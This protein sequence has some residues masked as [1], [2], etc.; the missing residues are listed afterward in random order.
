MTRR[1]CPV[2]LFLALGLLAGCAPA[3]YL[4]HP[5]FEERARLIKTVALMPP[6]MKVYRLT[7]GG[8]TELMDE[9]SEQGRRNAGSALQNLLAEQ[10]G[11]SFR[12][13]SPGDDPK[14]QDEYE[15]ARTL[16]QAV[17]NSLFFRLAIP[18]KRGQSG[19][20][21]GPLPALASATGAD[22]LL[23]VHGVDYISTGGRVALM[24][25][26]AMFGVAI[27]GG[28]TRLVA[29]LVD[30][31]TGDV[32]WLNSTGSGTGDLRNPSSTTSLVSTLLSG[33]KPVGSK[34]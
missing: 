16:F 24:T 21:L 11:Y 13:F 9:W 2:V 4:T 22:A 28:H 12:E 3:T 15:D 30:V 14:L 32:I 6:D 8:V 23:F 29:G 33:F 26:G 19:F 34:P 7:A 20:S 27:P 17:V 10:G 5:Q 1:A 25:I 18:G 31:R